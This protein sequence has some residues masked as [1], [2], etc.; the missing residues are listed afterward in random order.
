MYFLPTNNYI[1]YQVITVGAYTSTVYR[2]ELAA[3]TG[4]P[5]EELEAA[6]YTYDMRRP[7][8]R[9]TYSVVCH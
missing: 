1:K 8:C 3:K 6:D 4:H 5:R 7:E 9:Y 2:D